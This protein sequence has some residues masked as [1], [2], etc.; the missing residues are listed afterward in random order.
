MVSAVLALRLRQCGISVTLGSLTLQT[1]SQH[2]YERDAKRAQA[3]LDNPDAHDYAPLDL[4][5][6]GSECELMAHLDCIASC[7]SPQMAWMTELLDE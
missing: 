6:F 5:M 4:S 3:C 7:K 2:L 1:G